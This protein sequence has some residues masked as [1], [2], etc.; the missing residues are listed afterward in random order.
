VLSFHVDRLQ[1]RSHSTSH[2]AFISGIFTQV[3]RVE[4]EDLYRG[5][6]EISTIGLKRQSDSGG[7][8]SPNRE[9]AGAV[10][11]HYAEAVVDG[12][13]SRQSTSAKA[14]GNLPVSI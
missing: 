12:R 11:A 8:A 4:F 1:V 6:K 5:T 2:F 7:G 14:L 3:N 9:S 13:T 10:L